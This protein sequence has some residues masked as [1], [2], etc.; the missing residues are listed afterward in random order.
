MKIFIGWIIFSIIVGALGNGRKIGFV[1]AFFLSLLLS[2]V[3]GF[4]ITLLSKVRK[5]EKCKQENLTI[6]KQKRETL[7]EIQANAKTT[8]ISDE[9]S[10]FKDNGLL[11]EGKFQKAKATTAL[12]ATARKTIEE[13][14]EIKSPT[15]QII[16]KESAEWE[17]VKYPKLPKVDNPTVV[18]SSV[19]LPEGSHIGTSTGVTFSGKSKKGNSLLFIIFHFDDFGEVAIMVDND[20]LLRFSPPTTAVTVEC[21]EPKDG[22]SSVR[23]IQLA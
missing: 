4:I 18:R 23:S 16:Y 8:S 17:R 10:K 15:S 14:T 11:N 19:P 21:G 9:S 1:G 22:Y 20:E 3:I 2:P 12:L 6:Q 5:E 13:K 7:S